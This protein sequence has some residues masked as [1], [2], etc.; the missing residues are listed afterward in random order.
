V[1]ALWVLQEDQKG[2]L[3]RYQIHNVWGTFQYTLQ[4]D[5]LQPGRRQTWRRVAGDFRSI[6]GEWDIRKW[7]DDEHQLI[8]SESFV[9]V[10]FL[11]PTLFLRPW[12]TDE[13]RN[14]AR[15]MREQL[16]PAG[17]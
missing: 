3:V 14:T 10:A 2:A 7:P 17:K 12:L 15:L 9:D 1:E 11:I 8:V 5:Y 13:L 4:R 16:E 6:T